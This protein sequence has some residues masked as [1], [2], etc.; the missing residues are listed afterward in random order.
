[1]M[2]HIMSKERWEY[3]ISI[4]EGELSQ[5]VAANKDSLF[6]ID[7]IKISREELKVLVSVL[8]NN[9]PF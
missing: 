8:K 9:V 6:E 1:M 3:L 7:G 4:V 2:N 5:H